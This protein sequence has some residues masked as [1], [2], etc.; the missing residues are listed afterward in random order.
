MDIFNWKSLTEAIRNINKPGDMLMRLVFKRRKIHA[1]KS[2]NFDVVTGDSKLAAMST[3]GAPAVIV[4]KLGKKNVEITPP[5]IRIKKQLN[6]SD[7]QER[8]PGAMIYATPQDFNNFKLQ[9]IADEQSDLKTKVDRRYNWMCAQALQGGISYAD[10]RTSFTIDF[11]FPSA[12]KPVLTGT[13]LWTDAASDPITKI[14]AWRRQGAQAGHNLSLG[15]ITPSATDAL[16]NNTKVKAL[17]EKQNYKAGTIDVSEGLEYIGK[18]GGV[19]IWEYSEEYED[20]S[21]VFHEMLTDGTFTLLDPNAAFSIQYAAVEEVEGDIVT[22]YFSKVFKSDDPSALWLLA[23]TDGV[24]VVGQPK[25]VIH[26][27]VV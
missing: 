26:A 25:A 20:D 16:L 8:A 3:R 12:N 21:G 19:D 22:D 27:T 5:Q 9:K 23:E 17:L 15:L 10:G 18:L 13:D 24:P 2:V 4:D 1:S 6:P 14:R 7:F 11:G